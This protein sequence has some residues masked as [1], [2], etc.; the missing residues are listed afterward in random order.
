MMLSQWNGDGDGPH[1]KRAG[2]GAVAAGPGWGMG[3]C[4]CVSARCSVLKESPEGQKIA[5]SFLRST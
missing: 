3:V 1:G 5:P 4:H 2:S